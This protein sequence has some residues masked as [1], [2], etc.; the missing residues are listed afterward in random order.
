MKPAVDAILDAFLD[1]RDDELSRLVRAVHVL[2]LKHPIAARS[3]YAALAAEGRAF[4]QT[5]EGARWQQRLAGSELLRRGQSVWDVMTLNMLEEEGPRLLPSQYVEGLC[6][7]AS[8]AD[9]ESRLSRCA[10]PT[11]QDDG[12]SS[13]AQEAP[14]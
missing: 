10:M 12:Q 3:L 6:H 14:L 13:R 4:A 2:L 1:E 11:D 8:M 5:E 9:L 7:A